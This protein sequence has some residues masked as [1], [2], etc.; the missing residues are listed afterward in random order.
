MPGDEAKKKV[1][2]LSLKGKA[3]AWYRLCDGIGLELESIEIET[4]PK[5]YPMHLVHRDRNYIYNFWPC[6]GESIALAWGS[7]IQCYIQAPIMSSQ[8]KL[9]SRIFMLGFLIMIKP[10]L[11]LLVL[12]IL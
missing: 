9:L 6:E 4:S 10:C 2:H 3:L 1:S 5:N 8:E 7:R 11:I 12:D